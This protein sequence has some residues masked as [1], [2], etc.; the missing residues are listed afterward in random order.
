MVSIIDTHVH[1]WDI[2]RMD[3]PWL[4]QVPAI[5]RSFFIA[6]YQQAT[7][8][9]P[10]K[11]MVVVQG[12]CLPGQYL[13]EVAFIREEASKDD[14]I[15]GI[16]AWAPVENP[17][18]M[19]EALQ[20]FTK[21]SIVKGIRR[22]Y[23]HDPLL[24]T[25]PSFI[26]G[27]Q[28]LPA[29]DLSFDVS[30]MPHAM[31]ETIRMIEKCPQ[32]RFILDHLGKPGI[33]GGRLDAFRRDI[34]ILSD[35]PNTMAKISGLLT[36]A[37]E[38]KWMADDIAPYVEHALYRFGFDRLIFG[39][40]WPVVL[41]AASYDTWIA[42]LMHILEGCPEEDMTKLFYTNAEKIYHL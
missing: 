29:Y 31:N 37:D 19:E 18:Q 20:A 33:A 9:L 22:M 32:T 41:Q 28:Q 14:R 25:S 5:N 26:A 17:Y 4:E 2:K 1:L 35:F 10:I 27:L 21:I 39:S 6:D 24:C 15:R 40:D 7:Q 11:K 12:E 30:I 34:D 13:E 8:H 42:T 36:E 16:V 23:D 3:Y 38:E